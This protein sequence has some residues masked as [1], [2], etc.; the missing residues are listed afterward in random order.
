MFL[1]FG[2]DAH[3][4]NGRRPYRKYGKRK[5][6]DPLSPA[7]SNFVAWI[8]LGSGQIDE[9]ITQAKRTLQLDLKLDVSQPDSGHGY[10]EKGDYARAIDLYKKAEEDWVVRTGTRHHLR[11]NGPTKRCPTNPR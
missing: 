6:S 7:L 8:Y 9:A 4:E 11:E 10:R 2:V 1:A 3:G 5:S